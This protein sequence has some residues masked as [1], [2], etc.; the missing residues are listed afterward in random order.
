[1]TTDGWQIKTIGDMA[2]RVATGPF[3]SSIKVEHS[4]RTGWT[5]AI[6]RFMHLFAPSNAGRILEQES[7]IVGRDDSVGKEE[8]TNG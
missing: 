4:F 2:E 3:G 8:M 1:M 7:D 6:A 5:G